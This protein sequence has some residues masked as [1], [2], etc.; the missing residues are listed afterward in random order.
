MKRSTMPMKKDEA[1]IEQVW[2]K[3]EEAE[4]Q[5]ID[6]KPAQHWFELVIVFVKFWCHT[7]RKFE[8]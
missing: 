4:Y 7:L 6:P 5:S 2:N 3:A 8:R 1:C